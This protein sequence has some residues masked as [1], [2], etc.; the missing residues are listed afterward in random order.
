MRRDDP[1]PGNMTTERPRE[2]IEVLAN[3]IGV[4]DEEVSRRLAE[5]HSW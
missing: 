3:R 1:S 2:V 5:L 4:R